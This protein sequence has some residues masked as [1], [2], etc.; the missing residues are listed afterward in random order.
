MSWFEWYD[1]L[2]KPSWTPA[3]QT[4]GLVW[5]ILYPIIFVSFGFVFWQ[6]LRKKIPGHVAIPFAINLAANL[7]FS[8]IQFSLRN[9]PLAAVDILIVWITIP[10]A[11]FAV[12]KHYRWVAFAQ[13]PYFIWVSIAT[14]LQ[15]TMTWANW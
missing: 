14:V 8:P 4:I 15:L 3:P 13:I 6:A 11:M 2:Q 9:L 7:A 12:W 1:S 5:Q 10:W